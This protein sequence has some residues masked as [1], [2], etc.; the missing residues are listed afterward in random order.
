MTLEY[1]RKTLL[2]IDLS[3]W[4]QVKYFATIK[5]MSLN[6]AVKLLIEIGLSKCG[7]SLLEAPRLDQKVDLKGQVTK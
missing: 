7:Y 4:A 2:D 3:I 1:K 5:K 6:E